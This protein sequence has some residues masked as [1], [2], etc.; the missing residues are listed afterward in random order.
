MVIR[1]LRRVKCLLVGHVED[2]WTAAAWAVPGRSHCARCLRT[3]RPKRALGL[4]HVA[5]LRRA[6]WTDDEISRLAFTAVDPADVRLFLRSVRACCDEAGQASL[7]RF[8]EGYLA[9]FAA[10]RRG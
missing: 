6:G 7:V 4:E 5:V 3:Y 8:E 9:G 10:G 1:F 2:T